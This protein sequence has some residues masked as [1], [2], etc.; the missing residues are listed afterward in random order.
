MNWV[1][2]LREIQHLALLLHEDN[3]KLVPQNEI[4][5]R[6]GAKDGDMNYMTSANNKMIIGRSMNCV[7][8]FYRP[9]QSLIHYYSSV[10]TFPLDFDV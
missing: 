9:L 8:K 4:K 1:V 7:R 2:Y 6:V 5:F 3:N 10:P